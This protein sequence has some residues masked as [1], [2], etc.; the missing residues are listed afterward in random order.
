MRWLKF[1]AVG[2]MGGTVHLGLLALFV[3]V[4]EMN[5]LLATVVSVEA[6]IPH[7]FVWHRRLTWADRRSAE[8]DALAALFRFNLANGLVSISG[9]VLSAYILTGFWRIDPVIANLV[10]IAIGSLANLFLSDRVVFAPGKRSPMPEI[11]APAAPQVI[12]EAQPPSSGV[13]VLP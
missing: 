4:A 7:N 13:T 3:H 6:A 9:N 2:A 8:P 11:S 10:A 1:N 12:V 5:Y